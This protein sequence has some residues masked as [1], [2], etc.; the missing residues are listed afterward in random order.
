GKEA[1]HAFPYK[2][3]VKP[4]VWYVPENFE[5]AG[6][7]I[8]TTMEELHA[9]TDQIVND[10]G[11]PWCIGLGSGGATGLPATDWVEDS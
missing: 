7:K 1:L 5:K 6:Y 10:G 8:P 2:A 11:V 3:D 4:L 9:L